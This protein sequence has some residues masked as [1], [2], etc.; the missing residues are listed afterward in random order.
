MGREG[1]IE[2]HE[3]NQ[4]KALQ[5]KQ[6][7]ERATMVPIANKID[8]KGGLGAR[9]CGTRIDDAAKTAAIC[10]GEPVRPECACERCSDTTYKHGGGIMA[11]AVSGLSQNW[12]Q[13]VRI[14]SNSRDPSHI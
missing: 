6:Q 1:G 9:E 8:R 7:N 13:T 5:A 14:R 10:I 3:N 12:R 2:K 11:C 4:N